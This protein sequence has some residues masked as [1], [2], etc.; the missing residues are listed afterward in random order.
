MLD[1]NQPS[2]RRRPSALGKALLVF[3][4]ARTGGTLLAALE[5]TVTDLRTVGPHL[6]PA[7]LVAARSLSRQLALLPHAGGGARAGASAST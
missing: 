4:P 7:L 3:S 5:L 1:L 6:Q 2:L